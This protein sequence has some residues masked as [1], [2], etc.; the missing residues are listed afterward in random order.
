MKATKIVSALALTF[1]MTGANAA[2]VP[3]PFS[4]EDN[5]IVGGPSTQATANQFSGKFAEAVAFSG[6]NNFATTTVVQLNG[7]Q[8]LTAGGSTI[9]NSYNLLAYMSGTGTY[10][11]GSIAGNTSTK[12]NYSSLSLSLFAEVGPYNPNLGSFLNSDYSKLVTYVNGLSAAQ[13]GVAI[14]D[15]AFATMVNGYNGSAISLL[16]NATSTAINGS[17]ATIT[18]NNVSKLYEGGFN[19]NGPLSLTA[20]GLSY[21]I[22]PKDIDFAFG[23][24]SLGSANAKTLFTPGGAIQH[25]E[26]TA[27]MSIGHTVPEPGSIALLGMGMLGFVLSRK[28][29]F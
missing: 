18:F 8:G 27:T 29:Q 28:R 19:I 11:P 3:V 24:G 13:I 17:G 2:A 22:Q 16:G 7:L 15:A 26:D 25:I 20:L 4:I 21:L 10:T 23:D 12:Y 9:G 6:V 5:A 14:T 1:A